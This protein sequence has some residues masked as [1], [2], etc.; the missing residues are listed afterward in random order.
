AAQPIRLD[1]GRTVLGLFSRES[2]EG[3]WVVPDRLV[4]SA[5]CGEVTLDLRQALLQSTRVVVMATVILGTLRLVVP[6]EVAVEITSSRAVGLGTAAG[7]L[8]RGG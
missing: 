5:I 7:L 1:G 8:S 6:D 2:R 4:A 3:R